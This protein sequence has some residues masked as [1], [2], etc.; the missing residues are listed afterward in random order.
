[1]KNP[2]W[3]LDLLLRWKVSF[4]TSYDD[5]KK[6]HKCISKALGRPEASS[7]LKPPSPELHNV[8]SPS[9]SLNVL[10]ESRNGDLGLRAFKIP[11]VKPIPL[12]TRP[13]LNP[14][15]EAR[16]FAELPNGGPIPSRS[17]PLRARPAVQVLD[18]HPYSLYYAIWVHE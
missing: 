5:S 17:K 14:S 4:Q 8:E 13:A 2:L 1:M 15:H 9:L 12:S 10:G 16:N 6:L 3:E 18:C 7:T 11:Q